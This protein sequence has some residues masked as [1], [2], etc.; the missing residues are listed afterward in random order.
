MAPILQ[1]GIGNAS[2]V[3]RF[4]RR[5]NAAVDDAREHVSTLVGG[6]PSNVVFTAGA[7]EANN[8]A[9]QGAV[10]GA[11]VGRPRI[12]I[13]AVEH[14]SVRETA[15]WLEERGLAKLDIIPVTTGGYVDPHALEAIIDTDVMLLSVM[16]ANSETGVLNPVA[17]ISERA[18]A[19]GTLFHCDA[20]QIAGRLPF[21]IEQSG[22]DLIAPKAPPGT[23]DVEWLVQAGKEDWTVITQDSRIFHRKDERE[24]LIN[25]KVKCFI[26]PSRS[27]NAWDQVRGFVRMWDKIRIESQFP[28]PFVWRFNDEGQ[29]VRWEQLHP[30]ALGLLP[31]DL[32]RTPFGHLLN[33]FASVVHMHDEGWFNE[34]AVNDLHNNIRMELEARIL[35]DRSIALKPSREWEMA[36]NQHLSPKAKESRNV[37]LDKAISPT[38][39]RTLLMEWRDDKDGSVYPLLIP[40]HKIADAGTSSEEFDE[41][42]FSFEV[43]PTG[44]YRCGFGLR[45]DRSFKPPRPQ[46]S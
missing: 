36:L 19:F 8:L 3:H 15:R 30:K 40:G 18:R 46:R 29:P 9:L 26:V 2:S 12:L 5:Q 27:K 16:A 13:S 45:L 42:S 1:E 7:T 6:R 24:T 33:L 10:L 39:L 11:P 25:N 23:P 31:I 22:A 14:A 32:S 38:T 44:F 28:G 21:D 4:G 35:R 41:H 43:G 37:D 20:T 17:D 34:G